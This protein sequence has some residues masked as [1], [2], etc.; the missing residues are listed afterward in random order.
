[1]NSSELAAYLGR[2]DAPR[3]DGADPAD[4]QK[5]V[6]S[7]AT[8]GLAMVGSDLARRTVWL[9]GTVAQTSRAFGAKLQL[10]QQDN[11]TFRLYAYSFLLTSGKVLS[12]ITLPNNGNVAIVAMTVG[13]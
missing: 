10:Y 4:V 11:R 12:S 3:L 13:A 5:V 9:S 2:I 8:E 6:D 7:A 1:M